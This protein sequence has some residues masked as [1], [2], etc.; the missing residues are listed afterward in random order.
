[1]VV[2]LGAFVN[3]FGERLAKSVAREGMRNGHPSSRHQMTRPL[4]IHGVGEGGQV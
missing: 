1:M 2:D 3:V 4:H